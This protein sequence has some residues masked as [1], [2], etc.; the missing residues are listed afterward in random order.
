MQQ[1]ERSVHD[2][3]LEKA[4]TQCVDFEEE[5]VEVQNAQFHHSFSLFFP[6]SSVRACFVSLLWNSSLF[7][8]VVNSPSA[9]REL[10]ASQNS[11]INT[12]SGT[13]VKRSDRSGK[14]RK[15]ARIGKATRHGQKRCL[16]V[17]QKMKPDQPR[18]SKH[19]VNLKQKTKENKRRKTND[20]SKKL[21][22]EKGVLRFTQ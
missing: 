19:E 22:L 1:L 14:K 15:T 18:N 9:A 7:E 6:D 13:A 21:L 8:I 17:D 10:A 4:T 16:K 12:I 5:G 2:L 3:L 20:R 11:T